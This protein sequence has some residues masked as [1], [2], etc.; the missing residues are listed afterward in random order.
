MKLFTLL[1]FT[2]QWMANPVLCANDDSRNRQLRQNELLASRKTRTDDD[3]QVQ[4]FDKLSPELLR[5]FGIIIEGDTS[6]LEGLSAEFSDID[7]AKWDGDATA[8]LELKMAE[9]SFVP[10]DTKVEDLGVDEKELEAAF[11]SDLSLTK[12]P[13]V[14]QSCPD[15]NGFGYANNVAIYLWTPWFKMKLDCKE[16]CCIRQWQCNGNTCRVT[17]GF[18]SISINPWFKSCCRIYGR[19]ISPFP[20]GKCADRFLCSAN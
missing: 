12:Y 16:K 19:S 3:Q 2:S 7:Y 20:Y 9:T 8:T 6:G 10:P 5:R 11:R 14:L 18:Y 17:C 13:P 15:I 4:V 1:V